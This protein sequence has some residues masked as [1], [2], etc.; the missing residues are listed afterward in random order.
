MNESINHH[1]DNLIK[2]G[3][4][5]ENDRPAIKKVKDDENLLE[6]TVK[7]CAYQGGCKWALAEAEFRK[8]GQ[9]RCQRLGCFVGAVK[10]YM[11]DETLPSDPRDN[12][13]DK[14]EYLMTNV[15]EI[16]NQDECQCQGFVFINDN[17]R[18]KELLKDNPTKL[19]I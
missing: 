3:M 11:T 6:I 1:I 9:Y 7:K 13:R 12:Q 4:W 15:M 8:N 5:T 19:P 2:G 16:I 10:K 14:V 17:F 18:R